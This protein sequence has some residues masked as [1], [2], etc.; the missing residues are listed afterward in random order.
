MGLLVPADSSLSCREWLAGPYSAMLLA[1]LVVSRAEIQPYSLRVVQ[2]L[3]DLPAVRVRAV[4]EDQAA[5]GGPVAPVVREDHQCVSGK[6][7]QVDCSAE[8]VGVV[9]AEAEV[10]GAVAETRISGA[11]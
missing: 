3:A 6:V 1:V 10:V 8:A 5:P 7:A 11:L 9:V 4:L 2:D